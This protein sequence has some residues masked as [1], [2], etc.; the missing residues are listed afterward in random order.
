MDKSYNHNLINLFFE[1][2]RLVISLSDHFEPSSGVTKGYDNTVFIIEAEDKVR[3]HSFKPK[4]DWEQIV[5]VG[6][7]E[8]NLNSFSHLIKCISLSDNQDQ[9]RKKILKLSLS[10]VIIGTSNEVEIFKNILKNGTLL[11]KKYHEHY[12]LYL[13]KFSINKTIKEIS[14]QDLNYT[15]KINEIVSSI[16]NK[17]LT[18]PGALIAIGAIM[19]LDEVI[20]ALAVIVGMVMTTAIV[21]RS[22]R[23]HESTINHLRK[24]VNSEFK[25]YDILNEKAEI[26]IKANETKEELI[27][28]IDNAQKNSSFIETTILSILGISV[29]YIA[30]S[31]IPKLS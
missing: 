13:N 14:D 16:Q 26:R 22:L 5:T 23:V 1:S 25:R 17:A 20:D 29:I 4:L 27:K 15:S 24:Q 30:I 19:K 7:E 12:E 8:E 6:Y 11:K 3:K 18:I 21:Y 10:E 31:I 2:R 9:E 28:L